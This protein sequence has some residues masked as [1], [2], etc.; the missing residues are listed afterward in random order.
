MDNPS[1]NSI[2]TALFSSDFDLWHW[3]L[4]HPPQLYLHSSLI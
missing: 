3:R 2:P 1:I 4:G